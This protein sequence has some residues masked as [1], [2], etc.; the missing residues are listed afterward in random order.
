MLDLSALLT[1][2]DITLEELSERAGVERRRLNDLLA[3]MEPTLSDLRKISTALNVPLGALAGASEKEGL[4]NVMFRRSAPKGIGLDAAYVDKISHTIGNSFNLLRSDKRPFWIDYFDI[5][6]ETYEGAERCAEEFR[7]VFYGEDY[8]SP[9]HRLP[10]IV[11][12]D[13]DILL[14]QTDGKNIEGASAVIDGQP[15]I[16]VSRRFRPRML[17][18]LAHELGHLLAHI[19]EEEGYAILDFESED[20]GFIQQQK[21]AERFANAFAS[22]LLLPSAGVG[23]ALKKIREIARIQVD[24]IGD[25]EILYLAHIFGTSFQVAATRCE[26][27]SLLPKGGAASLFETL[28]RKYGSPEK[29]AEQLGLPPRPEIKFPLVPP[30]LLA[31]AIEK[32]KVGDVSLGRAAAILGISISDL[33]MANAPVSH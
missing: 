1:R 17:F 29:R 7:R 31:S 2:Y 23:V 12:E 25:V 19:T 8:V 30:V 27:L 5:A 28:K 11:V 4:A 20:W 14:F 10:D 21:L 15:F 26:D 3:G 16:F 32:I 22:V 6:E 9:L 18:T 13:M 24:Q 33:I